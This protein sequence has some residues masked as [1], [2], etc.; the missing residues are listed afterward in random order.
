MGVQ[1]KAKLVK[2]A[3]AAVLMATAVGALGI[4]GQGNQANLQ[5]ALAWLQ[6]VQTGFT[7][8]LK[9][10][11]PAI[12]AILQRYFTDPE[13]LRA[14]EEDIAIAFIATMPSNDDLGARGGVDR[15]KEFEALMGASKPVKKPTGTSTKPKTNKPAP[16]VKHKIPGVH[17][18]PTFVAKSV[19]APG[20]KKIGAVAINMNGRTQTVVEIL[21]PAP[22]LDVYQRAR[23]VAS[24]MQRM[25]NANRLWWSML[26]VSR[27]GGQYVVGTSKASD[28]VITADA[29]FAKEWGVS[30][31]T[32][33]KQL[34]AK[35]RS[36]VDAEKSERFGSR[37]TTPDEMHLAAVEL[38]QQGDAYYKLSPGEA[39]AKYKLAIDND[40]AY[41]VPYL[42]LADLYLA[43][44][45]NAAAR[46]ILTKAL[47]VEGMSADQ[48]A[49]V[50]KKLNTLGS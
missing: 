21:T 31:Q 12:Q 26:R 8:A 14:S 45:D 15:M 34:V 17:A 10:D 6:K 37:D 41:S 13:S 46:D 30:T 7:P 28:F 20:G 22:K 49:D 25:A 27:V 32:L 23:V 24:R 40:P 9:K 3:V 4:R 19:A 39:E 43:K 18:K 5:S 50:Q 48:K 29:A 44:R 35:I 2:I 16:V 11:V 42:R 1:M 36:S 38:R 47:A 33:A